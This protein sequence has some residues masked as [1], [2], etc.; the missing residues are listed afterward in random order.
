MMLI[1]LYLAVALLGSVTHKQRTKA[2]HTLMTSDYTFSQ[3]LEVYNL[4][5]VQND[6]ET[7]LSLKDVMWYRFIIEKADDYTNYSGEINEDLMRIGFD[8][9]LKFGE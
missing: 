8:I 4:D 6:P 9:E 2:Y 7:R 3:Y 5:F 1:K